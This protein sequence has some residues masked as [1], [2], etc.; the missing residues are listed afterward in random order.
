MTE[1]KLT[2]NG[3]RRDQ[4]IM[5]YVECMFF[6]DDGLS[7]D[8]FEAN[9]SIPHFDQ[10]TINKIVEDVL[11]FLEKAD[12]LISSSAMGYPQAGHDFWLTRNGHGAGFWDR[13]LGEVGDKLTEMCKEFGEIAFYLGEEDDKFHF[14]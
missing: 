3:H 14:E 11:K 4:M 2:G 8:G 7:S 1:L 12:E 5:G 10:E 13:G 9:Q 6:T